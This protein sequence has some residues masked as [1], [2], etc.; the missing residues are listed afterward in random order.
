MLDWSCATSPAD[1]IAAVDSSGSVTSA[2]GCHNGVDCVDRSLFADAMAVGKSADQIVVVLGISANIECEG[3]DRTNTTLPG[4][5]E[6]LAL[7]LL[8]LQKPT[9][10]VLLNGGI[11]SVDKLAASS[12]KCAVV[13]AFNP[14]CEFAAVFLFFSSLS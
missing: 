9:V 8:T 2:M 14:V 11:V 12:S 10:V 3:R 13:E 5:Q 1:A 6:E 4:M 7:E